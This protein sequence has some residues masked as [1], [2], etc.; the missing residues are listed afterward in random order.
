M[1]IVEF[2]ISNS[3]AQ[4]TGYTPFYLN[5][6][7]HPCTPVDVLRDANEATVKKRQPIHPEDAAGIFT[8]PILSSSSAGTM[9]DPS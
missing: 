8:S 1:A 3:P 4:S 7:Y 9:E 2:V 6:G 5:Y